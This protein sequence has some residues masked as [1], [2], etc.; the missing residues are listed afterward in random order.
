MQKEET[1]ISEKKMLLQIVLSHLLYV[2]P[3]GVVR[4]SPQINLY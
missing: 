1:E 2:F 4:L 3:T